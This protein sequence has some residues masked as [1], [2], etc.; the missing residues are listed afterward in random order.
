M[1]WCGYEMSSL[2]EVKKVLKAWFL[3]QAVFRGGTLGK[4]LD[5]VDFDFMTGLIC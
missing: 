1:L 5:R 3:K 4:C 2:K